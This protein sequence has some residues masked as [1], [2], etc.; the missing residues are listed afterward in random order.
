MNNFIKDKKITILSYCFFAFFIFFLLGF[1]INN[2]ASVG[3]AQDTKYCCFYACRSDG[4]CVQRC[5]YIDA[6][7]SC[8]SNQCTSN[9]QCA[10]TQTT[11]STSATKRCCFNR[12]STVDAK[13]VNVCAYIPVSDTCPSNRCTSDS[14]CTS[15]S[16]KYCCTYACRSDGICAQRCGYIDASQTCPSSSC[17]RDSDCSG[18]KQCCAMRCAPNGTCVETCGTFSASSSCPTD[19]CRRDADCQTQEYTCMY[20]CAASKTC[21]PYTSYSPCGPECERNYECEQSA[22]ENYT[23]LKCSGQKCVETESN[24]AVPSLCRS[25]MDCAGSYH[26]ECTK[27]PYRYVSYDAYGNRIIETGITYSCNQLYYPGTNECTTDISCCPGGN[28]GGNVTKTY[29][30]NVCSNGSCVKKSYSSPCSSKCQNDSDCSEV[31]TFDFSLNNPGN[32][33]V[34]K[35]SSRAIEGSNVINV[36]L[37]NGT[38][39]SV[40]F[41][42][43]GLPSTGVKAQSLSSCSSIPCSRTNTLTIEASA[44]S[45]IHPITITATG[46]GITR[47]AKYNLIIQEEGSKDIYGCTDPAADNYN[48]DAT[49]YDGSCIYDDEPLESFEDCIIN[50]FELP[51]RAWV[52]IETTASWSTNN[53]DT[54]EINCISDDC[55]EGVE[56]LSGSVS[57]GI[58]QSKNFTIKAPGTYRYELEAC[59]PN[60][61]RTYE[62]VLG[63][64]L[65]YIEIEALHLPWW[66]EIIPILPDNLQGFLRGIFRMN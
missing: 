42:Q 34:I 64:G 16:T 51:K 24:Y 61:C 23:Y 32:I 53:C 65:E 10:T 43:S 8:P 21:E 3:F 60:N 27:V 30:C 4:V 7:R 57:V 44:P 40:S 18:T 5:G 25:D 49:I 11:T 12:C 63:T 38:T 1:Y 48:P 50:K 29:Y 41:S 54:A 39:K 17:R 52:D 33:V 2:Y 13:C 28:C 56:N 35:P 26:K 59:G 37:D 6:S 58:N 22:V 62:D 9:S 20:C 31:T 45:G 19:S 14:Q 47:E 46:G 36:S 66:E 55:I 15:S